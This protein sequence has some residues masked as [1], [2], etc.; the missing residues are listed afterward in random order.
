M[1]CALTELKEKRKGLK[2]LIG[3]VMSSYLLFS[4]TLG[5]LT[6]P[7]TF[8]L[9]FKSESDMG[10]S[11]LLPSTGCDAELRINYSR[12]RVLHAHISVDHMDSIL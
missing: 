5:I 9:W 7:L 10:A 3:M 12:I 4:V 2:L 11:I 8:M 6:S 1:E